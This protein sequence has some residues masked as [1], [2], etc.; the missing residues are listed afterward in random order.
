MYDD[1][2]I[3]AA[4]K[5]P[6]NAP[7]Q[8]DE[9]AIDKILRTVVPEAS[10]TLDSLPD[11]S[12]GAHSD[13]RKTR[14]SVPTPK[15]I[16]AYLDLHVIGNN[17]AK[18]TLAVSV[19]SHYQSLGSQLSVDN[20][21]SALSNYYKFS[22]TKAA[23]LDGLVAG[24]T[25]VIRENKLSLAK[26]N[27]L[28]A[29]VGLVLKAGVESRLLI[30]K[31][32]VKPPKSDM[33]RGEIR[34]E[35]ARRFINLLI[36]ITKKRDPISPMYA[37]KNHVL[38]I[39]R[40][41]SGKTE[42]VEQLANLLEVPFL[43]LDATQITSTGYEGINL[44]KIPDYLKRLAVGNITKAEQGIVYID[45]IDKRSM[46]SS[47][48]GHSYDEEVQGEL[49]KTLERSVD[50]EAE[51]SMTNVLFIM[52]GSFEGLDKIISKRI[53][54]NKVGFAQ[55]QGKVEASKVLQQVTPEDLVRF[56]FKRELIGRMSITTTEDMTVNR[57]IEIL[58]N[59]NGSPLD[60]YKAML[61][62]NGVALTLTNGAVRA[63]SELAFEQRTGARGLDYV[64]R[65]VLKGYLFQA[66][67]LTADYTER[68]T[69]IKLDKARV[70]D[71]WDREHE[72][73]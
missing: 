9:P 68:E 24:L 70:L 56:G 47:N 39:G 38:I 44:R 53:N 50:P 11:N 42:M 61:S 23:Q 55:S 41:G 65:T 31:P 58:S 45:E 22:R 7:Q 62:H 72:S 59:P 3:S 40:S 17:R 8:A 43:Q 33:S 35:K 25:Q 49:L 15:E 52:S 46:R 14:V 4:R 10:G 20:V 34:E 32:L 71:L 63:I 6:R 27:P 18:E 2:S 13:S 21:R 51:F 66:P 60:R 29:Q 73:L 26:S 69:R 48:S 57:L 5:A 1:R 28:K 19:Y 64:L 16:K 67:E 30:N 12:I 37:G 36:G 54:P